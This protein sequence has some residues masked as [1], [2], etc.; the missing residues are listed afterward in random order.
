MTPEGDIETF[1][2]TVYENKTYVIIAKE[3]DAGITTSTIEV[4]ELDVKTF[5]VSY[6]ANGGMNA[7]ASQ[8]KTENV[9]MRLTTQVPTKP[10]STFMGWNENP[11]AKIATYMPGGEFVLDKDTRLFA[12]WKL[13][14]ERTYSVIYNANGGENAPE[15]VEDISGDYVITA[16]VPQRESYGFLGW[17]E[18]AKAKTATYVAGDTITLTKNVILYAIWEKGTYTVTVSTNP[19]AAGTVTGSAA[20]TAGSEVYISTAPNPGY[21]FKN[22]TVKSGNVNLKNTTAQA[23]SFTMPSNNVEVVANYDVGKLTVKYNANKGN[24]A[25]APVEVKY[26]DEI[27]ITSKEPTRAGYNFVGWALKADAATPQYFSI[28]PS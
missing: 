12:I 22:W 17:S 5:V 15:S 3:E 24:D 10:G 7:P 4:N 13:G 20:K 18:D 21:T 23:T 1:E 8:Q 14:E 9:I 2:I 11:S 19:E 27:E 6:D 25:P 28:N 26:E 16:E